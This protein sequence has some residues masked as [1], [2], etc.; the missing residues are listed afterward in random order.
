MIF[1]VGYG[2]N[3]QNGR[4][5][6]NAKPPEPAVHLCHL[7][8]MPKMAKMANASKQVISKNVKNG[9]AAKECVHTTPGATIRSGVAPGMVSDEL[10]VIG[11]V[12]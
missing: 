9:W 6:T 10:I 8:K 7:L 5:V 3:V 1:R 12:R 4:N 2:E 11:R